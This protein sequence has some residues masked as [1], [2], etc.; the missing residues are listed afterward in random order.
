MHDRLVYRYDWSKSESG[1]SCP[2]CV[3]SANA[4]ARRASSRASRVVATPQ[5]IKARRRVSVIALVIVLVIVVAIV[6]ST[7]NKAVNNA[8]SAGYSVGFN[9]NNFVSANQADSYCQDLWNNLSGS[10]LFKYGSN[11]GSWVG[12]CINGVKAAG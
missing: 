12:G 4:S 6:A 5:Q 8:Y 2:R 1:W 7:A 10:A 11:E 3:R 9:S